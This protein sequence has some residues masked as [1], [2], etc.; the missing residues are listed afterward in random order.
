M[1]TYLF[2][3]DALVVF[4]FCF[5]LF[6]VFG[7]LLVIWRKWIAVIHVPAIAWV[8]TLESCHLMCPLTELEDRWRDAGGGDRY[9]GGFIDH[10]IMPVLYPGQE[11]LTRD[12]Q[13]T[14]AMMLAL[15]LMLSYTTAFTRPGRKRRRKLMKRDTIEQMLRM[16]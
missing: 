15:L 11:I 13:I 4:H 6:V 8:I 5:V 10:Y 14:L 16:D 12:F 1:N 3:A 7:G 9:Q 2:M